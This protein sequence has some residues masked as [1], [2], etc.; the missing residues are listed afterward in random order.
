M[1]QVDTEQLVGHEEQP[2]FVENIESEPAQE[3]ELAVTAT[4]PPKDRVV[5]MTYLR[6]MGWVNAIAFLILG[7]SFSAALKFPGNN[8]IIIE[9]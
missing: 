1:L 2:E 4:R 5:Y 3:N 9:L 8:I 6:S 7:A